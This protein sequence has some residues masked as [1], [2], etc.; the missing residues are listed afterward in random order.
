MSTGDGLLLTRSAGHDDDHQCS[1]IQ[2]TDDAADV[3][4]GLLSLNRD[5]SSRADTE[6]E[7]HRVKALHVDRRTVCCG[8]SG[9]ITR[10]HSAPSQPA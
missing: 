3:V 10:I 5:G 4:G 1:L 2:S 9:T 6:N 8:R 7:R